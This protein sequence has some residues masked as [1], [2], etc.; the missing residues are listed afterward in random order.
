MLRDVDFFIAK[1]GKL[2][3]FNDTGDFLKNIIN[4]REVKNA[5]SPPPERQPDGG[6]ETTVS[7]ATSTADPGSR[8]S[9]E[10]GKTES[11]SGAEDEPKKSSSS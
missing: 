6:S 2:D 5:A 10:D 4:S 8:Q 7:T 3:G 11:P 1:L 9:A